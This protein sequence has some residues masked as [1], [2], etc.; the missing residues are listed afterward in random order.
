[1]MAECSR[2]WGDS[3]TNSLLCKKESFTCKTTYIATEPTWTFTFPLTHAAELYLI[4]KAM[5]TGSIYVA[6]LVS[7]PQTLHASADHTS[8]QEITILS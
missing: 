4:F 3:V 7:I 6:K 1:M 5:Y 8:T 2:N